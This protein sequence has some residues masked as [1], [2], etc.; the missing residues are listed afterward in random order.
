[1]TAFSHETTISSFIF[2]SYISHLNFLAFA[3]SLFFIYFHFF[4]LVRLAAA[5][6]SLFLLY[7]FANFHVSTTFSI[8]LFFLSFYYTEDFHGN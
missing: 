8:L 3:R 5:F 6:V 1:M 4:C 7:V 2:I